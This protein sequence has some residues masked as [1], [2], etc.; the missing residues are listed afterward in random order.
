MIRRGPRDRRMGHLP[1]RVRMEDSVQ[2]ILLFANPISGLGRG[3]AIATFLSQGLVRASYGVRAFLDSPE[4]IP[5]D[6]I[7]SGQPAVAAIVI[8]GDGTLRSVAERLFQAFNA[9][10]IPPLVVVPLGTANLMAKHLGI[11]W[12][13]S[14]AAAK[15]IAA[16]AH[17]KVVHLDACRANGQLFLL[18]AGVGMDGHIIHE[19][20]RVRDGPIDLASYVLPVALA[21]QKYTYPPI[22]VEVDGDRIFGPAPGMAFI[23]NAPEYGIGFPILP[24][25]SSDDGLLDVCAL[26]CKS[27]AQML[28]LLLRAASGEHLDVEGARYLKGIHVRVDADEPIPVQVDG[29]A[30]GF[31]PLEVELLPVKVPFIVP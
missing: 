30:G 2:E 15:I 6:R 8:G 22:R 11:D 27:R 9:L 21:M 12:H 10:A 18:M 29:E 5:I 13:G 23:A 28:D 17:R 4:K 24:H 19:L 3:K 26:P 1:D 20:D 7:R 25:A 14:T 16:I 31:T